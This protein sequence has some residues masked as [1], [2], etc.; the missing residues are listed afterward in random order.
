MK[1]ILGFT[2]YVSEN[3]PAGS[4]ND[5]NAPWNRSEPAG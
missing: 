4:E 5:P 2:S 1:K 3:Y